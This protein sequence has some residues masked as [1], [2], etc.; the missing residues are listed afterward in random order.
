MNE[1]R[2][3]IERVSLEPLDPKKF[4]GPEDPSLRQIITSVLWLQERC[5]KHPV[6]GSDLR[7]L[8]D[9][10]ALK[11]IL[12]GGMFY[13]QDPTNLSSAEICAC[14]EP[15]GVWSCH[16]VCKFGRLAPKNEFILWKYLD[17]IKLPQFQL[18]TLVIRT[19]D[20]LSVVLKRIIGESR[21]GPFVTYPESEL[22]EKLFDLWS[23]YFDGGKK[24]SD[25]RDIC[26]RFPVG[27]PIK[28]G[29]L[30][31]KITEVQKERI[32]R[33]A[34]QTPETGEISKL[35]GYLDSLSRAKTEWGF[36]CPEL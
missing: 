10:E 11:I 26:I 7:C 24:Q 16:L 15:L 32:L 1:N 4:S 33:R 23:L 18:V 8:T 35:Q 28:S 14:V 20:G 22:K 29:W 30:P 6:H 9:K 12:Q 17:S 25:R 34:Q 31:E 5:S 2:R 3:R 19:W 13:A 27:F 36:P 21:F